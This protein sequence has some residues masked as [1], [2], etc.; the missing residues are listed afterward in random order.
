MKMQYLQYGSPTVELFAASYNNN[1]NNKTNTITLEIGTYGYKYNTNERWL[2]VEEN[3]GIY[4]KRTSKNWWLAS[5]SYSKGIGISVNGNGGSSGYFG[6]YHVSSDS[7]AIC[8][9]V[10][11]PT[12]VFNNKYGTEAN[13]VDE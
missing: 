12:S 1:R 10:C 13:L 6:L 4:N 7:L 8:P 5:P 11:I 2:N 3:H 9:I